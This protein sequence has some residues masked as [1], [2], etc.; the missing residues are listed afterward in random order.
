VKNRFGGPEEIGVFAMVEEGLDEGG[1]P[2]DLFLN[3]RGE[4][5]CGEV[6]LSGEIRP[7][8][9]GGLRLKEAAKLGFERALVPGSL[10]EE[11]GG[12]TLASFRTLGELVDSLL[13]RG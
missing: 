9:H 11:R 7:V 5:V 6:A 3:H 2:S 12:M 4:A 13:G 1:N 8:A 10:K